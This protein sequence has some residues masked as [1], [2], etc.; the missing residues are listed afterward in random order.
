MSER[1]DLINIANSGHCGVIITMP[2]GRETLEAYRRIMTLSEDELGQ[3][4]GHTPP[5]ERRR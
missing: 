1:N 3:I 4:K 2:K 5:P